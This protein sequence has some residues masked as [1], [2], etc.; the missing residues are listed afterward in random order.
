MS[1]DAIKIGIQG[2]APINKPAEVAQPAEGGGVSF[3][4]MLSSAMKEVDSLQK[5]ADQEIENVTL[6]RGDS[7][8]HSAA[9]ALEKAEV[10]FQLMNTIRS[11][12]IRAYEDVMRTQV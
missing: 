12:I 9:L 4:D 2:I 1:I 3:G 8:P 5:A 10:A 6:G 11:K 7:T